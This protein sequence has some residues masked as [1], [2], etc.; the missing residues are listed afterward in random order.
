MRKLVS[1]IIC[2]IISLAANLAFSAVSDYTFSASGG[3]FTPLSGATAL[4]AIEDDDEL[5][6]A[7]PIG[8]TFV[9]DR[10]SYSNV[11]VSSNG[12]LTFNTGASGNENSNNLD[13]S[14]TSIRPLVAPLWDDLD[15]RASSISTASYI[16]DGTP[17]SRVFTMEWLNW[18]WGYNS[19]DGVLSFQ[20]KLYEADGKIE[21]IYRQESDYVSNGS[22]SIGITSAGTG[23]GNFISLDSAGTSP[24]ASSTNETSK[25]ATGQ[26]YA[27]TPRPYVNQLT[28]DAT[29]LAG[30]SFNYFMEIVNTGAGD[31]FDLSLTGGSWTYAIRNKGDTADIATIA[32]NSGDKDTAIVKVTVPGGASCSE[33]DTVKFKAVSQSDESVS[34]STYIATGALTA[35]SSFPYIQNFDGWADMTGSISGCQTSIPVSD[36]WTNDSSDDNDW[37]PRTGSTSSSGTGPPDDHTGGENYVYTEASSCHD[38]TANLLS[39]PFDFSGQTAIELTFWYHMYDLSGS[40]MGRLRVDFYYNGAWHNGMTT[41]WNGALGDSLSGNQGN[42]W[43][44]ATTDISAAANDSNAQIRF[45]GLTGDSYSDMAIDDVRIAEPLANDFS[46]LSHDQNSASMPD[47]TVAANTPVN[48]R[49]VVQNLGTTAQT[50]QVGWWLADDHG[51]TGTATTANLAKNEMDTLSFSPWTPTAGGVYSPRVF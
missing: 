7:I 43:H 20:V 15:G 23:N 38:H 1:F 4:D 5:S 50:S 41:N 12:W 40:G 24:N 10:S 49:I 39:P 19:G 31:V 33:A 32:L 29:V 8:F 13:F 3:T 17:G 48:L 27:F 6:A 21:F 36:C 46:A 35:I 26:V 37:I 47:T 2:V 22:A 18:E 45:C 28:A 9:Y 51:T 44:K 34:D 30:Q 11:K 14:T 25:P 42:V 16:T